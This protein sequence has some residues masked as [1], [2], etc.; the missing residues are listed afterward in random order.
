MPRKRKRETNE[1]NQDESVIQPTEKIAKRV[2]SSR[3]PLRGQIV[4]ISTSMEGTE[5]LRQVADRCVSL[6]ASVSG[7]VHSR[8]FCV[9]AS[10]SALVTA[11]Q[12]VRK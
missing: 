8:L 12:K 10:A 11:S 3:R 7:Q 5:T 2:S 1:A 9:I 6:G 4:A